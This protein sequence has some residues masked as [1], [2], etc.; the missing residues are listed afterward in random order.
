MGETNIN[1]LE[2]ARKNNLIEEIVMVDAVGRSGKGMTAHI[3]SSFERVE[4]QHNLDVFEWVGILW[5]FG[6]ITHDAAIALLR[7]EGD[8]RLY[9]ALIGRG[10]NFRPTDDTGVFKNADPKRYFQRLF[11]EGGTDAVQRCLDQRPIFQTC[12]HDGIRNSQ[13]FFDAFGERLKM[14]YIVRDPV[15]LIDEWDRGDFGRR[16]GA[17]P[18]EFQLT[19]KYKNEV[20]PY[21]AVGWEDEYISISPFDRV[22]ALINHHFSLNLD[23]FL[24]ADKKNKKKILMLNFEDI[25]TNPMPQCEIM[26]GFLNTRT[27]EQTRE[28]L[29][30]ERCPRVLERSNRDKLIKEIKSKAVKKYKKIFEGLLDKY[31]SKYWQK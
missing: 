14:I 2:F 8:T 4:K 31:E 23:G 28:I 12:V 20:V 24:Q 17:D 5:R 22:V 6:K 21:T 18:R 11:L 1:N 25:V 7:F 27:T 13:L 10:I 30:R 9:N 3:I 26:A 29:A 15:Y 16:I 19:V